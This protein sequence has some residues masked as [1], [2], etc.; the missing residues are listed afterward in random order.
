MRTEPRKNLFAA[1]EKATCTLHMR[2]EPVKAFIQQRYWVIWL[3]KTLVSVK[4]RCFLCRHFET[5]N[6]QPTMAPLPAFRFPIEGTK[7]PFAI[8]G[9]DFLAR[10]MLKTNKAKLRKF[11]NLFLHTSLRKQSI[12]KHLQTWVQTPSSMHVDESSAGVA[13]LSL[14]TAI[15]EKKFVG[16]S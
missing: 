16:A 4:Y 10:F 8:T 6:T 15:M 5:Q 3:R 11:I 2:T 7:S 12:W 1:K 14:C 13:N 9:L